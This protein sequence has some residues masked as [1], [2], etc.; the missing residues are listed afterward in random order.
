[1]KTPLHGLAVSLQQQKAV[2]SDHFNE[3]QLLVAFHDLILTS[4]NYIASKL[5][6][7][8]VKL[9]CFPCDFIKLYT[10]TVNPQLY[11]LSWEKWPFSVIVRRCLL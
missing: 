4:A 6:G 2:V 1:M 7:F 11:S 3:H 10:F 5:Q 8:D 9:K